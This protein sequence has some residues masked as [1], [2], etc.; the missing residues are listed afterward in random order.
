[1]NARNVLLIIALSGATAILLKPQAPAV[2]PTP[3]VQPTSRYQIVPLHGEN[4]YRLAI[5]VDTVT[6]QTRVLRC[7]PDCTWEPTK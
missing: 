6:G 1:M 2:N 5:K 3:P 7:F 4:P